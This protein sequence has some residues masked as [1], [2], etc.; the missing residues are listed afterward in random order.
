MRFPKVQILMAGGVAALMLGAFAA[1]ERPVAT[2]EPRLDNKQCVDAGRLMTKRVVDKQT[3]FVEDGGRAALLT[4][5][6]PCAN[7]DELDKIGFEFNGSSMI[8][9]KRDVKI[10][11]SRFSE[12]PV[13][14]LI[15]KVTPLTP[16]QAK[17]Y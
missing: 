14:C 8:C 11:Y 2:T 17:A 1:G 9:D 15:S 7:L 4:L 5:S 3:L 13:R 12:K 6:S 16:E 10:L